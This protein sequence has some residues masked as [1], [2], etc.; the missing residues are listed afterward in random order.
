MSNAKEKLK[1]LE[2]LIDKLKLIS[3]SH[4]KD[5]EEEEEE[6]DE[7]DNRKFSMKSREE[8]LS[9]MRMA[10]QKLLSMLKEKEEKISELAKLHAAYAAVETVEETGKEIKTL[11]T[12]IEEKDED[13]DDDN[14]ES[15]NSPSDL[16][17]SQMKKQLNMRENMRNKKKELEDL[18]RDE[19]LSKPNGDQIINGYAGFLKKD[20]DEDNEEEDQ[21]EEDDDEESIIMKRYVSSMDKKPFQQK[22]LC[23]PADLVK[24]EP[25]KTSQTDSEQAPVDDLTRKF[26]EFAANQEKFNETLEKG[27]NELKN[28]FTQ[29][30]QPMPQF[31][32]QTQ[33]Q[34]QQ[35]MFNL[36]SAYHEIATQR[37]EI[38]QLREKV[39]DMNSKLESRPNSSTLRQDKS[40]T[41][42]PKD[43]KPVVANPLPSYFYNQRLSNKSNK[44]AEVYYTDDF[45]EDEEEEKDIVKKG[46]LSRSM[47]TVSNCSSKR[48][49]ASSAHTEPTRK[50]PFWLD[51][52]S[53]M[54]Y[55]NPDTDQPF[56]GE[57]FSFD[58]MREKIYSEVASLISQNE[59]RPFYLLNLF[60]ELQLLRDKESRAKILKSILEIANKRDDEKIIEEP[61]YT[62]QE[63]QSGSREDTQSEM[64][65]PNDSLSNTVIFVKNDQ[66]IKVSLK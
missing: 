25:S 50:A 60:R 54:V 49:V 52:G 28:S 61:V 39:N 51:G 58:Q 16:L 30:Q 45:E 12:D 3:K 57:L 15:P 33:M 17:W 13:N 23:Q 56:D 35:L 6:D 7:E 8:Q 37:T 44:P 1:N 46:D 38:G 29:Q 21:E 53:Q 47:S 18:I 4:D 9:E 31:Q 41:T 19:N 48:S 10:K 14:D 64:E 24:E 32:L 55:L 27:F 65:T 43:H 22:N 59:T 5:D 42:E 63:Y 40:T 66:K 11:K 2:G 26:T 36:N 34:M 20:V 62:Y